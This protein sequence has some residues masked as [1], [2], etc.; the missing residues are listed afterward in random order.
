MLVFAAIIGPVA[1]APEMSS[2]EGLLDFFFGAGQKQHRTSFFAKQNSL[3]FKV[4]LRICIC[5]YT[6]TDCYICGSKRFIAGRCRT[7]SRR[8]S[9]KWFRSAERTP[10]GHFVA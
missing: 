6:P 2:V 5:K 9:P 3:Y 7:K 10:A 8:K 1:L 4:I